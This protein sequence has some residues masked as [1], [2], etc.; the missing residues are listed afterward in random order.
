MIDQIGQ[1]IPYEHSQIHCECSY[2]AGFFQF[3]STSIGNPFPPYP[4]LFYTQKPGIEYLK[5]FQ[6][7]P[8]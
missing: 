5:T 6:K 8:L 7:L 1:N 4:P 2:I 3:F